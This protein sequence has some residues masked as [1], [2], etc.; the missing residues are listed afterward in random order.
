MGRKPVRLLQ[1][2]QQL[3]TQAWSTVVEMEVERS[4]I[5]IFKI[6]WRVICIIL[7]N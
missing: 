5:N 2:P 7:G 1:Y 4:K 3:K 6:Y